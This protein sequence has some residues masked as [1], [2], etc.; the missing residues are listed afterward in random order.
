MRRSEYPDA[1]E[2]IQDAYSKIHAFRLLPSYKQL[3]TAE[4][5]ITELA[6]RD[7]QAP[8]LNFDFNTELAKI[9]TETNRKAR[10]YAKEV[11][12]RPFA[13]RQFYQDPN[14]LPK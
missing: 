6:Y 11:K 8:N 1:A 10:Q 7:Y 5:L 4:L 2:R 13:N 9:L 12:Y 3:E 14:R